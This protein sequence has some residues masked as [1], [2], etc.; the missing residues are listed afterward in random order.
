MAI[1]IPETCPSKASQ[2]EKRLFRLLAAKLPDSFTVWY[3]P[4]IQGRYPDFTILSDTFG[5]LLI[6][7]KGWYPKYIRRATDHEVELERVTGQ[8]STY[9]ETVANPIRQVRDYT[10]DLVDLL[11]N[12]PLLRQLRFPKSIIRG[13]ERFAG[14]SR[15]G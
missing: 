11:K 4:V 7:V 6:E 1:M 8:G 9:T 3:E 14:S 5:L 10:Y 13:K 15:P 12:E 2:G